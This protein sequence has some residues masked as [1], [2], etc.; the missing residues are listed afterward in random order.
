MPESGTYGSVRGAPSNGRPYRDQFELRSNRRKRGLEALLTVGPRGDYS[1]S[2]SPL[3]TS[4]MNTSFDQ[5]RPMALSSRLDKALRLSPSRR[6]SIARQL[7][8]SA[9]VAA[10]S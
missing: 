5:A 7:L 4:S 2:L 6:T 9:A 10:H 1:K 3:L 8:P